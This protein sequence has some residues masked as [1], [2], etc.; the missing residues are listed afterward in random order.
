MLL[1]MLMQSERQ[2]VEQSRIVSLEVPLQKLFSYGLE[3]VE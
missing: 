3:Q 2:R 1:N